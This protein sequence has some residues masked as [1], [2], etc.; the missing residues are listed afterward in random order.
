MAEEF[1]LSCDD[2]QRRLLLQGS[3]TNGISYLEVIPP[4]VSAD[5]PLL[6][7][8]CYKPLPTALSAQ[9]VEIDGG[10]RIKG[11]GIEWAKRADALSGAV[12]ALVGEEL[13]GT[14][15]TTVLVVRPTSEGDFSPYTLRLADPENPSQ[16]PAG[17]DTLLSK[18]EFGFKV[19]CPQNFDCNPEKVCPPEAAQEPVIDYLAKDYNSFRTLM[20][21]RLSLINPGWQER[22]PADLGV[23]L[24]EILAYVGDQLSYYQDA[25]ATEAYLGTARRRVSVRRH[26]R[27]LDYFIHDGCNSRAWVTMEIDKAVDGLLV[28]AGTGLLTGGEGDPTVVTAGLDQAM[29]GATVFET[30]TDVALYSSHN[31]LDFYTWQEEHCCLPVGGTRVTLTNPGNSLDAPVFTWENVPG[32]D[33]AALAAYLIKNYGA[34]WLDHVSFTT[35]D[36]TSITSSDGVHSLSITLSGDSSKAEV[37]LDGVQKDEFVVTAKGGKRLVSAHTLR[38][39]DVLI[40]EEV[41][42]PTTG[43]RADADPSH[44]WAV[45][46]TGVTAT[47]DPLD[48]TQTPLVDVSWDQADSPPFS[49]CL[50]IVDDPDLS[51]TPSPVS[52][53]RGNVVLADNGQTKSLGRL[54]P[55]N[56]FSG[57]TTTGGTP[58]QLQDAGAAWKADQWAGAR[59]AYTSGP[60]AGQSLPIASNTATTIST[61]A[62]FSPPPT[63]AGGDSFVIV[64][65]D[66]GYADADGN[67][68]TAFTELLGDTPPEDSEDEEGGAAGGAA[69]RFRPGLSYSPVTFAAP[70]DPSLPASSALG[71]DVRTALPAVAV[72]G[73]S[74]VWG[75]QRDL[76]SSDQ[77]AHYFVTEVEGDGTAYLRFGDD[78]MG[79]APAPSAP[80]KPNTFYAVYR[81]GN[82]SAGNVGR[83]AISRVVNSSAYGTCVDS[84]PFD[85]TGI[86]TVRNPMEAQ[87]GTDPEDVE[88]VRKFAPY[89]FDSQLRCV[90]AQD[91]ETVMAKQPGIQKAYAQIEWTGSWWTVYVSVDRTGGLEVDAPFKQ[92]VETFL[93]SYRMAGYDL[94]VT[95][96]A[97]VPLDI[98]LHACASPGYSP[99]T[100]RKLLL[101]AFSSSILPDGSKGFFHPDNFSFGQTVYLSRLYEV[102]TSV[103]GVASVEVNSFQRYGKADQGELDKGEIAIA[104]SEVARLD[105]DPNFPE[106]GVLKVAVDGGEAA[107]GVG[108]L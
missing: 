56:L 17:F 55:P 6:V 31:L 74:E 16:P 62:A 14:D 80:G 72:L 18:I 92:W 21:N 45:R 15:P 69:G 75:P 108:S 87:G 27:L 30:M 53:A 51:N 8:F 32:P 91:Y 98:E 54:S 58:T 5:L 90:T 64:A 40:F 1:Q 89:A 23:A 4:G 103:V 102:A 77:S 3:T 97:Y 12:A 68:Y 35:P 43:R 73:E 78:V 60:A 28:P 104:A 95:G 48:V 49:L 50:E 52:V 65:A 19:E 44:R 107:S 34:G 101:D 39:G 11:V 13:D 83:E 70:F 81:V 71:Y 38:A 105:N 10:A 88:D 67:S 82:G 26:A 29:R 57:T 85:A 41:R 46:I 84:P 99:D 42:S 79:K 94:E 25:V 47:L 7:V 66:S 33:S 106:N 100:V 59:L 93:D 61:G 96:P 63:P 24:V 36:A 86:L 2:A 22:N 37:V 20:L 9:N 76:F